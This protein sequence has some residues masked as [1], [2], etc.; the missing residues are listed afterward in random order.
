M[1]ALKRFKKKT[2]CELASRITN[3]FESERSDLRKRKKEGILSCRRTDR[4]G[5]EGGI[6]IDW[7]LEPT[8]GSLCHWHAVVTQLRYH[9]HGGH[10]TYRQT[11][12]I[13]KRT[14][15]Q[16]IQTDGQIWKKWKGGTT[17]QINLRS[18]YAIY[19]LPNRTFHDFT[20]SKY[21]YQRF[22]KAED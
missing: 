13:D 20:G 18:V 22:W 11:G 1:V 6:G 21:V 14:D 7:G 17:I 15:R 19:F 2:W 4:T 3:E 5:G 8:A 10:R 12:Q 16:D 9:E